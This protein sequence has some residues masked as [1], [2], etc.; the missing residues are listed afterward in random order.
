MGDL[1]VAFGLVLVIEGLLWG[2]AP[3]MALRVLEAAK[4]TSQGSLQMGG[5][6][7]V[8]CGVAIVWLIRG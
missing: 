7:A 6:I 8:A 5:W 4:D 2:L 1:A 3:H